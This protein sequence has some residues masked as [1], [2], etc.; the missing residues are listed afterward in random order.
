M[1]NDLIY[2]N[3]HSIEHH[4]EVHPYLHDPIPVVPS[5]DLEQSEEGH[6]KVLK[7]SM[8]AHPLTWVVLV[9]HWERR[10]GREEWEEWGEGDMGEGGMGR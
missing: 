6:A 10:V 4:E 5:G 1:I 8:A 2:C 3:K 7:G 9:T